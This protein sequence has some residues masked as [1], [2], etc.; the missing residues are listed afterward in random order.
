MNSLRYGVGEPRLKVMFSG[1]NPWQ[2]VYH[3]RDE[4]IVTLKGVECL[5]CEIIFTSHYM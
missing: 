3:S 4:A 2:Y 5:A 1:R